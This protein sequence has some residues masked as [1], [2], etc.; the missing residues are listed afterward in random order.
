M[1][2]RSTNS[3][4]SLAE[5]RHSNG[6]QFES[7]MAHVGLGGIAGNQKSHWLDHLRI[8]LSD[9]AQLHSDWDTYQS[10]APNVQTVIFSSQLLADL[11]QLNLSPPRVVPTASESVVFEWFKHNRELSIE[12]FA[13]YDARYFFVDELGGEV[14]GTVTDSTDSLEPI[15]RCFVEN[16]DMEVRA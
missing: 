6:G 14:E 2:V 15:V 10:D 16:E 11:W 13:P 4:V 3:V 12:V 1:A 7:D 9:I 8:Q 5:Y